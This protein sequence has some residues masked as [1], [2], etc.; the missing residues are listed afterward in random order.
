M[1]FL[2]FSLFLSIT[3]TSFVGTIFIAEKI[4]NWN[5]DREYRSGDLIGC[6]FCFQF[7]ASYLA[8]SFLNIQALKRGVEATKNIFEII[9]HKPEIDV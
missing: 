1:G 6:Y 4:T 7:G 2:E 5:F 8:F 3:Y 9:D